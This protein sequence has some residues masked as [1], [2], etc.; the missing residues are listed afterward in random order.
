MKQ[1]VFTPQFSEDLE[2][3]INENLIKYNDPN[4]SWE[5]EAKSQDAIRE[6]DFEQPD[7][8]CMMN[9]ADNSLAVNDF[10]AGKILFESYDH[11]TPLHA[12]QSHFWLYL[13]HVVLYKYMCMRWAKDDGTQLTYNN[14]NEHWF[15]GQGRIRNWLEGMYWSFKCTAIK[16]EDGTYDYTYTQFLFSIQ[17]LRDRGIGAATYVMSN[18]SA[19]RGILKFYMD[20]LGKKDTALELSVFDKHFEYRTDKCIQLVN[21]LGG[22]VDIGAY[23]EE[24]FYN[25][26]N[27]NREYIKSVGDRKKEK[28]DREEALA[29]IGI[30]PAKN[31]KRKKKNKKHWN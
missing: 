11:L 5:E 20:E 6:L 15:Y 18:P 16:Q 31:K 8:S 28:K 24:D 25:F 1:R 9:Y 3:S 22:L 30:T 23:S 14:V 7:L 17:K 19:I 12:A 2:S 4:Y 27:D 13:S 26:L 29:A 10:Y 21:K